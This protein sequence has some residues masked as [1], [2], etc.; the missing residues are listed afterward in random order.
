MLSCLSSHPKDS[1][2]PYARGK[3]YFAAVYLFWLFARGKKQ[4][5]CWLEIWSICCF[6]LCSIISVKMN[7]CSLEKVGGRPLSPS[8][9]SRVGNNNALGRITLLGHQGEVVTWAPSTPKMNHL[10]LSY[11]FG[12][13][14]SCLEMKSWIL[15]VELLW[16]CASKTWKMLLSVCV[17]VCISISSRGSGQSKQPS[18]TACY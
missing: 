8:L 16:V 7:I 11:G 18:V 3:G 5:G 4:K 10:R 14:H 2:Y 1:I 12:V 6:Y 15:Q 13:S 9:I 17:C